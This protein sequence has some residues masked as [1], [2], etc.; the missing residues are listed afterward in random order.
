M[1][2]VFRLVLA[3]ILLDIIILPNFIRVIKE[4]KFYWWTM[5]WTPQGKDG[6]GF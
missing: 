1:P 2:I 4:M 5:G 3:Q 6:Q